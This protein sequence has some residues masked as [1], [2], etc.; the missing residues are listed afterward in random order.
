MSSLAGA[1]SYPQDTALKPD[2]EDFGTLTQPDVEMDPQPKLEPSADDT[3][4]IPA[5]DQDM[6]DL[7]GEDNAVEEAKHEG[8]EN[9]FF[10]LPIHLR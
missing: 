7:F 4:S 9:R 10:L 1:L 6:H 5:Q 8:L 3:E 2:P